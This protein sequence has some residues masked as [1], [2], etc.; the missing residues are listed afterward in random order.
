M[1]PIPIPV[2]YKFND[3]DYSS[4]FSD[5][6]FDS[7]PDSSDIDYDFNSESR[8]SYHVSLILAVL[9]MLMIW[10]LTPSLLNVYLC[11]NKLYFTMTTSSL[12]MA[13]KKF[14]K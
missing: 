14:L 6:D 1:I 9:N 7:N 12:P 2:L 10:I 3:F 13:G 11:H 5:V 8:V 4:D